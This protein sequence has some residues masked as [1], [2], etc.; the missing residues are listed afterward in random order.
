MEPQSP[1]PFIQYCQYLDYIIIT[2]TI[3][4]LGNFIFLVNYFIIL[5]FNSENALSVIIFWNDLMALLIII[6]AF[7][8]IAILDECCTEYV[9]NF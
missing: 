3:P 7:P 6:S 2:Y 9:Y 5:K 8:N 1:P 4:L